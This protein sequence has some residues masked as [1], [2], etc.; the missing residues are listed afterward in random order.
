MMSI[1][2]R[3]GRGDGSTEVGHDTFPL[4][5][6]MMTAAGPCSFG[7]VFQATVVGYDSALH[8][9][10]FTNFRSSAES[11]WA[12]FGGSS[13]K[14]SRMSSNRR[15]PLQHDHS[16]SRRACFL[17]LLLLD[18]PQHCMQTVSQV[19]SLEDIRASCWARRNVGHVKS[20]Q[21][22][23]STRIRSKYWCGHLSCKL[24][25]PTRRSRPSAILGSN[26]ISPHAASWLAVAGRQGSQSG[27]PSFSKGLFPGQW[28]LAAEPRFEVSRE[29]GCF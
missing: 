24:A 17:F 19:A 25:Q 28:T 12:F 2:Q 7:Y 3:K 1:L 8:G 4:I 27:R 22:L 29:E 18:A 21:A 11:S 10:Q 15:Q 20:R 5:G 16:E 14:R 9:E 26:D 6:R 13:P 23:S